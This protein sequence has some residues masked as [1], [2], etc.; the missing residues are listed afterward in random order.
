[1]KIDAM[2]ETAA[3][4]CE[5]M[6]RSIPFTR[7]ARRVGRMLTARLQGTP[8]RGSPQGHEAGH[9]GRLHECS[10]ARLAPHPTALY[11]GDRPTGPILLASPSGRPGMP[12]PGPRYDPFL[13]IV[14]YEPESASDGQ[15]PSCGLCGGGQRRLEWRCGVHSPLRAVGGAVVGQYLVPNLPRAAVRP[16]PPG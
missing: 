7:R 14:L 12:E 2:A 11:S 13:H 9:L 10:L 1:M 3:T 4:V 5:S 16:T 8:A 15:W 6:A